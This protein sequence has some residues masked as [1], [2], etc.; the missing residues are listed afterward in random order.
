MLVR[1]SLLCVPLAIGCSSLI[2]IE[3]EDGDDSSSS[4]SSGVSASSGAL[5]SSSSSSG[6]QSS[7][8]RAGGSSGTSGASSGQAGSSG[9]VVVS[10]AGVLP[11]DAC[12]TLPLDCLDPSAPNVIEVPS[13]RTMQQAVNE[14]QAG[15]TIQ[16]RGVSLP[17][18]WR[19]P[20]FVTLRGCAGAKIIGAIGFDG[21]A[22]T[23]EGFE[24]TGSLVANKSGSYVVRYNRFT[25]S[26]NDPGVDAMSAEP[27][28]NVQVTMRAEANRFEGRP[29]GIAASTRYDNSMTRTVAI[30][31]ENN[32][33]HA[34]AQPV[35]INQ[36]GLSGQVQARITSN[37]LVG[38]DQGVRLFAQNNPQQAVLRGNLFTQGTTAVSGAVPFS[39]EYT[40]VHAVG[41]ASSVPPIAGAF[42]QADP[43]FVDAAAG[44]FRVTSSFAID[45]IPS[46][47]PVPATDHQGCARPAGAAL[48]PR[49]DIGAYES[50]IP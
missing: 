23:V 35:L 43:G 1:L 21:S 24:I 44:D 48:P 31:I 46:G 45:A 10:D 4:G 3:S 36:A 26:S 19:V 38:F 30:D 11:A 22:G 25:G 2:G 6:E 18:G 15:T 33:F 34:V 47:T 8:G 49:A 16:L 40:I 29:L 13:E 27:Y 5:S 28:L 12:I 9:S 20:P 42:I 37:T 39:V 14:A 17:A 32:V 7:S 50:Q 41:T